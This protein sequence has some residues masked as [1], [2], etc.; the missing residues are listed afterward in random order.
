MSDVLTS[1]VDSRV[2]N[3]DESQPTYY[4]NLETGQLITDEP[5]V[6][7]S[8]ERGEA[9]RHLYQL[10]AMG[11]L[12]LNREITVSN[13]TD[14][15]TRK[16]GELLC[17]KSVKIG[18][19]AYEYLDTRDWRAEEDYIPYGHWL[20]TIISDIQPFLTFHVLEQASLLGVGPH[21]NGIK[22]HFGGYPN[23]YYKLGSRPRY[24]LG[25]YD[26]WSIGQFTDY[27]EGVFTNLQQG[28]SFETLLA[29]GARLHEGPST[30]I[31][32]K[33]TGRP[34]YVLLEA[35]GYCE[36]RRWD[37]ANYFRWGIKFMIANNGSI[38]TRP[39]IDALAS[40]KRAPSTSAILGQF[41]KLSHYQRELKKV[42]DAQLAKLMGEVPASS[43]LHTILRRPLTEIPYSTC[44][45]I[46]AQYKLVNTLIARL[47]PDKK[48]G[49]A[50]TLDPAKFL[51]KMTRTGAYLS[52]EI[53]R[54]KAEELDLSDHIWPPDHIKYLKIARRP[55]QYLYSD[56]SVE[57]FADHLERTLLTK[58]ESQT[59]IEALKAIEGPSYALIRARI[60]DT[61]GRLL[62][63]RGYYLGRRKMTQGD[64]V[65]WGVKFM[66]ANNGKPPTH[67][68]TQAFSSKKRG[69]AP[70][71]IN[72]KFD[73]WDSFRETVAKAY[74]NEL[75]KINLRLQQILPELPV[76]SNLRS[77]LKTAPLSVS[78]R[79]VAQYRLVSALGPGISFG[80]KD[81]VAC[82]SP[83]QLLGLLVQS[84]NHLSREKV[85]AG[86]RKLGVYE[87]IWPTDNY[88]ENL[89]IPALA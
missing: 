6:I 21:R 68:D 65:A 4:F 18:S 44:F 84:A 23:Y 64:L 61:P 82:S 73:S 47:A 60:G 10:F 39:S 29:G 81:T 8:I 50:C 58:P 5:A 35:R 42:F 66:L 62:E 74:R 77:A 11:R 54:K 72:K 87:D 13:E 41:D 76:G 78:I 7:A 22:K 36:C 86:A 56:W 25:D 63:A 70:D 38:P 20:L 46:L 88:W 31:I 48:D 45:R 59:L 83:D 33:R 24:N 67:P 27:V 15:T 16:L 85:Q 32:E 26:D 17:D 37:S 79:L 43:Q 2:G 3:I 30:H 14:A 12:A 80:Y 1:P 9:P 57:Q 55:P 51:E 28:Q 53:V 19:R 71:L 52:S 40:Q 69:P 75:A 89:K 34:L 49:I